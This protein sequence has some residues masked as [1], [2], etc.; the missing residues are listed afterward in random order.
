MID[1]GLITI[2]NSKYAW[3][4]CN[5]G[6][7][8]MA[9]RVIRKILYEYQTEGVIPELIGII[10]RTLLIILWNNYAEI[11]SFGK[12]L[13]ENVKKINTIISLRGNLMMV[14]LKENTNK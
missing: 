1:K 8:I 11:I 10:C 5:D 12:D 13:N 2:E 3:N 6:V 14:L 7:D 9:Y 4:I